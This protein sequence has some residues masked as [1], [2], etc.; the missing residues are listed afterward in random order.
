VSNPVNTSNAADRLAVHLPGLDLKNPVIPAS[1]CFG[2][3][4]EY[5][6]FYDLNLLGA[7]AAK[8]TTLEPRFGNPTPRIA[9]TPSGM[10]NS[11]GLENPGLEV[12]MNEKMPWLAEHFPDLPIIANV[13]GSEF[14]DYVAVCA[15]IGD[16]PNVKA[17]E[18]NISCPNVKHGGQGLGTDPELAGEVV[19][20]C[21]EVAK[22]PLYAKLSPNVT[23]I[24]PIAIA[25]EEA[26]ADG[27]S[28]INCPMG[29]SIDLDTRK[30]VIANVSGGLSGPAVKP[31][32]LKLLYQVAHVS[33]LPI[34]GIGGIQSAEDVLEYF[35]AGASAIQ[36][37]AAN[38]ADPY[39]CPKIIDALP[40]AMDRYGV[41]SLS[42]LSQE[43]RN[44]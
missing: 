17:I 34:I 39:I 26:G 3:G 6:N 38:F 23:D 10:I 19:K 27:F 41:E 30:P 35:M 5:S 40:A 16:A 1:G 42:Q 8:A 36:V 2:F 22:V 24:V 37:G 13:A 18:L 43:A 21:K 29:T 11:I 25:C 32:S 15:A 33:T 7:I 12:V 20:L 31:I 44:V 28:M 4:E 9:E 14:D